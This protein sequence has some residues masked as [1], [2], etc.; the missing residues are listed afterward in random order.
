MLQHATIPIIS[1]DTHIKRG[2][3]RKSRFYVCICVSNPVHPRQYSHQTKPIQRFLCG[4]RKGNRI[5]RRRICANK[6]ICAHCSLRI[7]LIPKICYGYEIAICTQ[8]CLL[9]LYC[10][11]VHYSNLLLEIWWT[12]AKWFEIGD[13]IAQ[14]FSF[15]SFIDGGAI[16][17]LQWHDQYSQIDCI[18]R[19][20]NIS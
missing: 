18:L 16:N 7:R 8:V 10:Y 6:I 12:F 13:E 14:L 1:N 11:V 4:G 2:I 9:L 15:I 17:F 19:R 5:V 3:Q 20:L